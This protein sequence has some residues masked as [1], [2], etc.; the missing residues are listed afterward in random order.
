MKNIFKQLLL[1]LSLI[2]TGVFAQS[3]G[4]NNPTP[5]PSAALDVVST[6]KGVL[7]PRL[8]AAQRTLIAN[9]AT[10]LLVYQTDEPSGFY[11]YANATWTLLG[12]TGPQGA[13][14]DKG[15]QGIQ[16]ETGLQGSKGDKGDQGI[17]GE[18]GLQGIQ[19]L[20]G[21]K[22]DQGI[23]GETGLQGL[24]GD[25]GD[26]GEVGPAGSTGA[27]GPMGPMG[28]TGAQGSKG[29]KGDA[30]QGVPT[31]GTTGQVL[32]KIDG[33]DFNTQWVTLSTGGGSSTYPNV[34]LAVT[35]TTIQQIPDLVTATTNTVLTFSTN[36]NANASLSG[37]NTWDGSVFTV[38]TTGAGWYQINAQVVGVTTTGTVS[39]LGVLYFMDKNNTVGNSKS[40]ALYLSTIFT[41]GATS[42][43]VIRQASHLNT[44]I[45]LNAG[46]NIRFRGWSPST[47]QA[48]NTAADGRTFLN[49]MRVK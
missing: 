34:E 6:T 33:T 32:A 28:A 7:V 3:V 13:K 19:G 21:D 23:Q 37:G 49:I 18:T 10:G 15:D 40:G 30:G 20:K 26:Q 24:N 16:G 42:D 14:G 39:S 35:N 41:S 9:P 44:L 11:F 46:D 48:A 2:S 1:V 5:D 4:V 43:P 45:Y 31:G 8:T 47:T 22:G 38:G 29:D 36:N 17:Q 25:K 27:T 12:A